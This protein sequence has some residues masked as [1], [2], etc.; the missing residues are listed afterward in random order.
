MTSTPLPP[1]SPTAS[2]IF[3]IN[4]PKAITA[5]LLTT[6][7]RESDCSEQLG[8]SSLFSIPMLLIL[9]PLHGGSQNEILKLTGRAQF[10]PTKCNGGNSGW[11]DGFFVK[12]V[13]FFVSNPS[14]F[15]LVQT[16]KML[17]TMGTCYNFIS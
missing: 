16:H 6:L 9:T 5:A 10:H 13:V 3:C 15:S 11:S 8:L 2:A 1:P 17:L 7:P 14:L 4:Y 12:M